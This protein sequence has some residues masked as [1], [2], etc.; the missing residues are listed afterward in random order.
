MVTVNDA[1]AEAFSELFGGGAASL[2]LSDPEHP[3]DS[4]VDILAQPPGKRLQ[5]LMGLSGGERSL[6]VIA[7]L[8]ALL[9]VAPAPFCVLDEVDAALDDANV[10]RFIKMV[11]TYTDRTQFIIV[12]HNR[13]TMEHADDLYG[14]TMDASGISKLVAVGLPEQNGRDRTH[15]VASNPGLE[16]RQGTIPQSAPAL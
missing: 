4:G 6:T 7:L 16:A 12:T 15:D 11:R 3:L 2:S 14:V 5:S 13:A 8:M 10:R 1:F 9:R